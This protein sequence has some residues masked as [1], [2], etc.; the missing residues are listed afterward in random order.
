MRKKGLCRKDSDDFGGFS[1][2]MGTIFFQV[3]NKNL[4]SEV[5]YQS[6]H[7]HSIWLPVTYIVVKVAGST[8]FMKLLIVCSRK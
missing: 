2:F 3:P 1:F 4:M 8:Y 7:Q 6:Q 5:I